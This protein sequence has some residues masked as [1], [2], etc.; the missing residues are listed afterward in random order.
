MTASTTVKMAVVA[1]MPSARVS[2]TTAVKPGLL[3]SVRSAMRT[4]LV[5]ASTGLV[6]SDAA[7]STSPARR[8]IAS[9]W[10]ATCASSALY[11]S[12]RC[13][14]I[15][16]LIRRGNSGMF[17][18]RD[19]VHRQHELAPRV[20]LRREHGAAGGGQPVV[21]AAA[22]TGFFDPAAKDPAALFQAIQQWI[23]G[24]D[25]ELQHT[26]GACLDEPTQVV[27]MTR[28]ILDQRQDEKLGA[29]LLQFAIEHPRPY[30]LHSDILLKRI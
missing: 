5:T 1:P 16:S 11:S 17:I 6:R 10:L 7:S 20:A 24:G 8:R 4:S 29:A 13:C 30:I 9:S 21:A 15:S 3:R 19:P 25:A 12:S 18:S 2:I 14:R 26:L 22:L 28:L 27:A 23:Q